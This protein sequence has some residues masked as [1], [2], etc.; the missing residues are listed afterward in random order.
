[1]YLLCLKKEHKKP[2]EYTLTVKQ[3][4]GCEGDNARGKIEGQRTRR[5]T[6][7]SQDNKRKVIFHFLFFFQCFIFQWKKQTFMTRMVISGMIFFP[8]F[9]MGERVLFSAL[10]IFQM[11]CSEGRE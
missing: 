2:H 6:R 9:E 5:V 11:F 4:K 3:Q 8:F 7:P 10:S 1:M